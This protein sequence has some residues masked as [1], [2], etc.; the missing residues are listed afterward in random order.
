VNR[1][2]RGLLEFW[3][4]V[5]MAAVVGFL[6]PFGT[7]SQ[8]DFPALAWRWWI[9]LMGAYILIRPLMLFWRWI[10][11]ITHLP[12]GFLVFWGVTFCSLPMG[13]LWRLA[14]DE[15][16]MLGGLARMLPFS[17]LCALAVMAVAWW[18]HRADNYLRRRYGNGAMH[19]S[20]ANP[21]PAAFEPA[22]RGGARPRLYERLSNVFQGEILALESEDHYV[23]VH[24]AGQSEL[25]YLRLRD[26]I[27]EM[28]GRPGGQTHRSWWVARDAVASVTGSGR[29]REISLVNGLRIPVARDSVDRL[30][31]AGILPSASDGLLS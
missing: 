19:P 22:E 7:Y 12:P 4:M 31:R 6:G 30:E 14:G 13:L 25:L 28:D 15:A 8:G 11:R 18:A 17:L 27:A 29:N 24:G 16:R 21:L 3:A 26:A 1:L 10:A 2:R 9:L 5:A 23:R 20:G